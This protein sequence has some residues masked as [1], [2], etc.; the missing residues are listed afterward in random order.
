M[1]CNHCKSEW[2]A[3]PSLSSNLTSCPFCGQS[4][5]PEKDTLNT[6]EDVL[7]EINRLFG[8]SVL[9]DKSKI[10]AYFYDLAPQLSRQR[11]ILKYFVECNGPQK[12]AKV[13]HASKDEQSACVKR[14]V[15]EMTE[16]LF[17]E[18]SASQTVC[19][20]FLHALTDSQVVEDIVSLPIDGLQPNRENQTD[21]LTVEEQYQKGE[22]YY[23]GT[24]T[25]QQ[26]YKNAFTWY[27]RAALQGHPFAQCQLGLM[28]REG[29]GTTKDEKKAFDWFMKAAE[30]QQSCPRGKFYVARSYHFGNGVPVDYERAVKWYLTAANQGDAYAQL[31]LGSCFEKGEGVDKNLQMAF[32]WYECAAKQEEP[33]AQCNLGC[34]Y[35]QGRGVRKDVAK[36]VA[37]FKKAADHQEPYGIYMLGKC[38]LCGD[39]VEK[40]VQQAFALIKHAAEKDDNDAQ[41]NLA[42][43]YE[44]GIWGTQDLKKAF[45]WYERAA[46]AGHVNAQTQ[47]AKYYMTGS[48]V[49]K[50]LA[51]AVQWNQRAANG[52]SILAMVMLSEYYECGDIL[53]KDEVQTIYWLEKAVKKNYQLAIRSFLLILAKKKNLTE[54]NC[55]MLVRFIGEIDRIMEYPL[56]EPVLMKYGYRI[57]CEMIS[58]PSTQY[59]GVKIIVMLAK[60]GCKDAQT[61][62]RNN[63][64]NFYGR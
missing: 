14:I 34:M 19:D 59:S 45:F 41:Y 38:Y 35:L 31:N 11:R 47:V 25:V 48:V 52:G 51:T 12:L 3:N 22:A 15:K 28:Y 50:D 57:S 42:D 60:N 32:Y 39:G 44:K 18:E 64:D 13:M 10:V 21:G 55:K 53:P 43:G 54:T 36:A 17:I 30:N 24:D 16:E 46:K 27:Q 49:E 9:T 63:L 62:M 5:L 29:R 20:A 6:I 26:N 2:S 23:F 37:L 33:L 40:D 1:K 8:I 58:Y 7:I 4:L 61:W 56:I